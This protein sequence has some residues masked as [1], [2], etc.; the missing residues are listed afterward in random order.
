MK[1][2]IEAESQEEFD[3]KRNDLL[4]ML[5]DGEFD[6]TKAFNTHPSPLKAQNEM[7]NFWVK[8]WDKTIS[9]IKKEIGEV[10]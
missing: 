2:H 7:L 1:I 6:L 8:E 9:Q 4:V 10:I 3:E 5:S